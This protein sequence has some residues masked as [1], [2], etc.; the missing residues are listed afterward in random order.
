MTAPP[1]PRLPGG[2]RATIDPPKL[3][4]YTL[5]PNH[6]QN[7]GKAK[8]W[9]VLGYEVDTPEG[10]ERSAAM[11]DPLI[12]ENARTGTAEFEAEFEDG[13]YQHYTTRTVI[14]GPNGKRGR[15]VTSWRF[16]TETRQ[17]RLITTR[18]QPFKE[19]RHDDDDS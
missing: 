11:I 15:I 8:G 17:T 13:R 3:A 12:R 19:G 18:V 6:P 14:T 4:N 5:D 9:A 7:G 16:D 1:R 10:R 2:E